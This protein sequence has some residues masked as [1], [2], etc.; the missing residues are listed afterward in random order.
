MPRFSHTVVV[1]AGL[2]AA[3]LLV[4]VPGAVAKDFGPGDLSVCDRERCVPIVRPKIVA[5]LGPFYYSGEPLRVVA[6]PR[7]GAASFELRFSNGYATGIVS[8]AKLDRFLS[9]GVHLERFR[10]GVWYRVPAPMA[11]ELR[12]LAAQLR[13]IPL[14]RESLSKSR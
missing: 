8:S 5:M 7:L 12:R 10:R 1:L 9:Y 4:G 3:L 6:R 11:R 14:T 2:A 13:P